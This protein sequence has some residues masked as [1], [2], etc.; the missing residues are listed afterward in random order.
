[1][2]QHAVSLLAVVGLSDVFLILSRER[3]YALLVVPSCSS[4]SALIQT[5]AGVATYTA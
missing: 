2:F 4:D 3:D 1:M 5:A